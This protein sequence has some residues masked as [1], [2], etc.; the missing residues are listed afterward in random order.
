M[1]VLDDAA[2]FLATL[3]PSDA[4]NAIAARAARDTFTPA[5]PVPTVDQCLAT[6][7][8]PQADAA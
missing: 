4:P 8:E 5:G 1:A 3:D 2:A 7:A 6:W